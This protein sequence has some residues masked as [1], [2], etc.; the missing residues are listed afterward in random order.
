M[1]NVKKECD[2]VAVP[3]TEPRNN[4][5][6]AEVFRAADESP[7]ETSVSWAIPPAVIF[8]K[9]SR[10]AGTRHIPVELTWRHL[11]Q[12]GCHVLIR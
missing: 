5:A 10:Q 6:A 9:R 3:A 2:Q 1:G 11:V 8:A 4:E 12:G 7:E